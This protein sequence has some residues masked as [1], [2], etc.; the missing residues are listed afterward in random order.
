MR[1]SVTEEIVGF[2]RDFMPCEKV[3]NV[4][5]IF[6]TQRILKISKRRMMHRHQSSLWRKICE[7]NKE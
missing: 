6:A 7:K 4:I 1:L 3:M 2:C 5:I